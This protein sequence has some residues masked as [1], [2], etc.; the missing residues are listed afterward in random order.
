[1]NVTEVPE[2]IEE[3]V[4]DTE[5]DGV[6]LVVTVPDTAM[7]CVVAL[8]LA[9]VT[10]PEGVPV[11]DDV[12]LTYIVVLFTT[13]AEGVIDVLDVNVPPDTFDISN[14]VGAVIDISLVCKPLPYT[15]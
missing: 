9:L 5:T 11:A 13:P 2:H 8:R 15:V 1:M 4:A 12:I 10:F 14:P 7:F 3:E 6:T